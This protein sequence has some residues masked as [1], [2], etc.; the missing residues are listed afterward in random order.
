MCMSIC[1]HLEKPVVETCQNKHLERKPW[2]IAELMSGL[3][4]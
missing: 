1:L 3:T 4:D 2:A